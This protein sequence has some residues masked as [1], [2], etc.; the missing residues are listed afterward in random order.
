MKRYE[1]LA[2]AG[3]QLVLASKD[4]NGDKGPLAGKRRKTLGG[5]GSRGVR[6]KAVSVIQQKA[7]EDF[8]FIGQWTDGEKRGFE[9]VAK[10]VEFGECTGAQAQATV[11]AALVRF[12]TD[13]TRIVT[14]FVAQRAGVPF[15]LYKERNDDQKRKGGV[16]RKR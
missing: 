3:F 4:E 12:R 6:K 1:A 8:L 14:A 11:E 5:A 9:V 16:A 13:I 10:D 15:P 2:Q 7:V